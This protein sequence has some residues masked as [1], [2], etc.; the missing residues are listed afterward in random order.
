MQ[1]IMTNPTL[2]SPG[3]S[4]QLASNDKIRL[5]SS[6]WSALQGVFGVAEI[7]PWDGTRRAYTRRL[8]HVLRCSYTGVINV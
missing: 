3:M 7:A 2:P 6:Q 8:A 4:L 1:M 5:Q